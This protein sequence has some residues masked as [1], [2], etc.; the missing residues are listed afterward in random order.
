[1]IKVLF[2]AQLADYAQC[3]S[4]EAEYTSGM[5]PRN[6]VQS[7]IGKLPAELT[8]ALIHDIAMVAANEVMIDWDD[9]LN[10]GD[11][12]AFLPPFSGG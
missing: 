3:K 6:L 7:L 4:Y 2:F 5:T 10:D 12:V 1:M 8:D 9:A 11:V